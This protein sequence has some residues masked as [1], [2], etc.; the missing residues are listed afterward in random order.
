MSRDIRDF[1]GVIPA[2][3]SVFGRDESLDEAGTR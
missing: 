1:K 3:L 2:V